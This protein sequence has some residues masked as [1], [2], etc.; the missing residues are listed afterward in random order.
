MSAD[1]IGFG[2]FDAL[3]YLTSFDAELPLRIAGPDH[4]GI[5]RLEAIVGG[6][7]PDHLRDLLL[8]FGDASDWALRDALAL[9]AAGIEAFYADRPWFAGSRCGAELI[10]L[11]AARFDIAPNLYLE[12]PL[13]DDGSSGRIV[14]LPGFS[15][16]NYAAVRDRHL[17]EAFGSIVDMLCIPT[18]A[19]EEVDRA[20][21]QRTMIGSRDVGG[22]IDD[23]RAVLA[24][25]GFETAG[26]SS[27]SAVALRRGDAMVLLLERTWPLTVRIGTGSGQA[28]EIEDTLRQVLRFD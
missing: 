26:F 11:G 21:E 28:A 4:A 25:E 14:A 22:Q 13:V 10:Y 24:H 1:D 8:L 27:G 23:A 2:V 15:A 9:S 18:F 20:T 16:E 12:R 6:D 19:R 17:F 5:D 7:M 3:D